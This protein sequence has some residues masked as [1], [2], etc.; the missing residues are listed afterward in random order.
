MSDDPTIR[1]EQ[2]AWLGIRTDEKSDAWHSGHAND[3]LELAS[4]VILLATDTGGVWSITPG[5]ATLPLSDSWNNPDIN[6]LA[7]GPDDP[8]NHFFAGCSKGIIRETDLGATLPLLEWKEIADPLP[9]E[10]GDVRRI[11][12]IRNLRR[13]VAACTGGLF[14][15]TIPPTPARRGCCL[16]PMGTKPGPRPPYQWR[17]ARVRG[18]GTQGFWDVAIG[19][20]NNRQERRNLEDRH[21]ITVVA[22]AFL[23]G[24]LYV[25]QWDEADDL[26]LSHPSLAFEDGRD[27]TFVFESSGTSCVSSCET[28]PAVL[29]AAMAWPD[30]RLDAILRSEDGGRRWR[31]CASRVE[32]ESN[33]LAVVSMFAGGQGKDWNN[34]IAASPS[35]PGMAALGWVEGPFITLDGGKVWKR[36]TER[37]HLHADIHALRFT[38]SVP[39]AVHN[40]YVCSD[41]GLA[42]INLDELLGRTGQPFQS[43]YNRQLPT[44]QCY[45]TLIRQFWG[46]MGVS[47]RHPGLIA[48][49]LQDNGNV[50]CLT[51]AAGTPWTGVDGGDGGWNAFLT[52]GA[53][54]HNGLEGPVAATLFAPSAAISW[55][56]VIAVTKP[57]LP[58]LDG[59]FGADVTRPT[60]RNADRQL[61]AAVGAFKNLVYGLYIDDVGTPRYHWELLA[62]LPAD[63]RAGALGSFHGGTV[64]A[65]TWDDGRMFAIDTRQGSALELP[66]VLPKPSPGT[67]MQ[68]GSF[69]RIVAFSESEVFATLVGATEKVLS[70]VPKVLASPKAL[71]TQSYVMRLEGLK[72]V[73]T[74]GVGL[75]NEP[76]FGL[77][78]V[79][80]PNS[81]VPRALFVSTDDRVYISRD[82]GG[83]WQRASQGLPRRPHCAD[84]RVAVGPREEANLFLST[85]GRSVWV[86]R[87]R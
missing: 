33:P 64:F 87:L 30:G 67:R 44:L 9:D 82:D 4:G 85:Y 20:T 84:I 10:A 34:C 66:V 81:R 47:D 63:V 1:W 74:P 78:A 12:V 55:S 21:S 26:V 28:R 52:D 50:F 6:C 79:A 56:A 54:T 76:M 24:G 60:H 42:R 51:G 23:N 32:G 49:G 46:T 83:S 13:I 7:A 59:P 40:L 39:G 11:V 70:P 27:A 48:T 73:P 43:N 65:G 5:G 68:G 22:G 62:T 80:I 77:E 38:P 75:P 17:Q 19:A 69:F 29:Y 86:A 14:W 25:G 8:D 58:S 36:V 57:A 18:A 16:F 41:G 53:W 72:F 37:T 45:S 3:M 31:F 2:A 15:A 71:V 35:N 61:L